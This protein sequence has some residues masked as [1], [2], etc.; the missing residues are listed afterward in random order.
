MKRSQRTDL[1]YRNMTADTEITAL[2]EITEMVLD[3]LRQ[4]PVLQWTPEQWKSFQILL[5]TNARSPIKRMKDA[6][7]QENPILA[8]A[9]PVAPEAS[10][11][12]TTISSLSSPSGSE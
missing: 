10:L 7:A 12:A 1:I 8:A 6:Q 4:T 3:H 5:Q 2:D 11:P 9:G